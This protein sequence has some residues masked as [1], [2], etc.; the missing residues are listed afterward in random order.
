[1]S[2]VHLCRRAWVSTSRLAKFSRLWVEG[3]KSNIPPDNTLFRGLGFFWRNFPNS[4]PVLSDALITAKTRFIQAFLHCNFGGVFFITFFTYQE[5]PFWDSLL[6]VRA[7]RRPADPQTPL[8]FVPPPPRLQGRGAVLLPGA[9]VAPTPHQRHPCLPRG[10]DGA[11]ARKGLRYVNPLL[12]TPPPTG[13]LS[14]AGG[15]DKHSHK[16]L[17]GSQWQT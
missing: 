10:E 5:Y 11:E 3:E 12:A 9:T 7:M 16:R 17:S 15:A 1:M 4:G 13:E 8:F 6:G 14:L 2:Y